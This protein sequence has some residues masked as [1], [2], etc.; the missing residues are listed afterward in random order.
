[1]EESPK[2][3]KS[4]SPKGRKGRKSEAGSPMLR[5]AQHD[6]KDPAIKL[7][8]ANSKLQTEQM[9]VHHDPQLDRKADVRDSLATYDWLWGRLDYYKE[10]YSNYQQL[11]GAMLEKLVNANDLIHSYRLNSTGKQ[12]YPALSDSSI[13]R[14]NTTYL[15]DFLNFL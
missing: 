2:D 10:M 11:G 15:N 7:P 5:Q 3:G 6:K 8:T 14:I 9:E 4:G 1:M 13:I 12:L